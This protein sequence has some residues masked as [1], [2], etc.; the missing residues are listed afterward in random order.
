MKTKAELRT[1]RKKRIRKKVWGTGDRPRL[2]VFRSA[3]HIYAQVIDDDKQE[4]MFAASSRL[5][6]IRS[7]EH[8]SKI[9]VAK[10]VGTIVAEMCIE[11][12]IKR[13]VFDRSGFIYHG[14][15]KAL[16]EAARK[17]GLVF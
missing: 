7:A 1:W 2:S 4:T 16:A 3:S 9:E 5:K 8:A 11:H 6:D 15:I 14:R 17:A 10:K 13:V 12:D